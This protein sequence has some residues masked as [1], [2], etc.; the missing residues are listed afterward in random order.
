MKKVSFGQLFRYKFDN[1]MSKGPPAM[2]SLLALMS[3]LVVAIAGA[4]LW[5]FDIGPEGEAPL[6]FVEGSWQSLMRT[7][8][9]GT[10]SGDNGW[11]F[12]IFI[13]PVKSRALTFAGNDKIIVLAED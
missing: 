5:A 9:A 11:S 10:M 2:M 1:L 6:D 12:G 7:L 4:I 3:L 13:H 8:D